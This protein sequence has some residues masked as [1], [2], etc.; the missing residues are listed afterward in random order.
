M[1]WTPGSFKSRHNKKLS[2]RKAKIASKVA[3]KALAHGASE[4]KAII[5]GNVA[6]KRA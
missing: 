1:P 5:A 2:P 6:A 3:N 4:K